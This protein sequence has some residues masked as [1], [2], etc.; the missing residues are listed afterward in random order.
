MIWTEKYKPVKISELE[1]DTE[2]ISLLKNY[3]K[4]YSKQKKKAALLYGPT[5][6]GKTATIYALANDLNCDIIEL[7]ASD[8]RNKDNINRIVSSSTQQQSLFEKGKIILIDEIDCLNGNKDRGGASELNSLLDKSSFP[9]ILTCNDPWGSK[10]SAIRKNSILVEFKEFDYKVILDK[11]TR[12]A[13]VEGIKVKQDVLKMLARRVGG[14]L[15]AA[16][17]DLQTL[18]TKK[19]IQEIDLEILG[20]REQEGVIF[21]VLKLI[22]KSKSSALVLDAFDRL[23]IDLDECLLWLDENIPLEYS[24]DDLVKAYDVLSKADVFRG[25]I[26]R[27]QHWHFLVYQNNLMTAGVAV[28]KKQK[29]NNLISYKRTGRI[30]KLWIAKQRYAKRKIIAEKIAAKTHCSV[31]EAVKSDFPYLKIIFKK[32]KEGKIPDFLRLEQEEIEYLK[33]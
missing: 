12:V 30:L 20:E 17:N 11:L 23:G 1:S 33:A 25:R 13:A 24:G 10:I 16:I 9:I 21:E 2:N 32:N 3:I 27:R 28:A 31:K 8:I 22:F 7:N 29:N 6:S 26:K 19:E 4:N 14:D 5:G 18:G 15:R